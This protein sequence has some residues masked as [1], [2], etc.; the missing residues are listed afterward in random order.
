[1]SFPFPI[2]IDHATSF[3][4]SSSCYGCTDL[5]VAE[6]V[7]EVVNVGDGECEIHFLVSLKVNEVDRSKIPE[8]STNPT[9]VFEHQIYYRGAEEVSIEVTG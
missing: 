1:M 7:P 2:K 3:F 8:T 4:K 9:L 5:E 6:S